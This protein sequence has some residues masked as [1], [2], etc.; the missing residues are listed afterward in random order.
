M[1]AR[2]FT[3][4]QFRAALARNGFKHEFLGWFRD[5]TDRTPGV[6]Y[7]GIYYRDGKC[8][9]RATLAHLIQARS[10]ETKQRTAKAKAVSP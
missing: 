10:K 5:T 1:A 2:D 7:G 3:D 9:R 6:S 8:A 4:A